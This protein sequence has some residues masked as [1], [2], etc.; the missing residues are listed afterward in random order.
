MSPTAFHSRRLFTL[1]CRRW[2]TAV[3]WRRVLRHTRCDSSIEK[4]P[5]ADRRLLESATIES[6]AAA[7]PAGFASTLRIVPEVAGIT[8]A[9]FALRRR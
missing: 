8:L 9:L 4:K 3:V 2:V 7:F 5:A 1:R 6:A